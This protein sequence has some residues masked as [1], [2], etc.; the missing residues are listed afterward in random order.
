MKCPPEVAEILLDILKWGILRIRQLSWSGN[1]DRWAV[2]ADHIHNLPDLLGNYSA[3]SLRFYWEVS[4]PTFIDQSSPAELARF[5][6]LWKHLQPYASSV[7][8]P[9]Q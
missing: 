4:R 2:E 1:P 7:A 3:E 6:T 8:Q 5:E 9:A